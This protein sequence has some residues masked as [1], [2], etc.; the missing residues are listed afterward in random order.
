AYQALY[1]KDL[2]TLSETV[3]QVR[4][5]FDAVLVATA[6]VE[7][8]R[9]EVERARLNYEDRKQVV[10][11]GAVSNEDFIHSRDDLLAAESALKQAEF[12]LQVAR[13]ARG[14]TSIEKH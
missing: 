10:D 1:E 2:A 11:T 6:N 13:D 3:L 9:I 8:K 14:E 7:N 12:E 5:L 4:Q